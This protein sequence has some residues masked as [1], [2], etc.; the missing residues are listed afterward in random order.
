MQPGVS[1]AR[2]GTTI[3]A[4]PDYTSYSYA[5]SIAPAKGVL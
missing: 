1:R 4:A 2:E 3:C 5:K